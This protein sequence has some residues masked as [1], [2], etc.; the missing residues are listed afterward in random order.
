MLEIY[1]LPFSCDFGEYPDSAHPGKCML[2]VKRITI[3]NL[4][5]GQVI[6]NNM[7]AGTAWSL[8]GL[9]LRL[10]MSLGLHRS[11]P[12]TTE[13]ETKAVRSKVWCVFTSRS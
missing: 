13:A 3:R 12:L 7:N 10:A 5:D 1:K 4:M 11:C 9:T 8:M 6:S 2:K